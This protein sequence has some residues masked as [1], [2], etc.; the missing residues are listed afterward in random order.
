MDNNAPRPVEELIKEE[1]GL[2]PSQP[3]VKQPVKAERQEKRKT[4]FL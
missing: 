3:N 1:F 2:S 4:L